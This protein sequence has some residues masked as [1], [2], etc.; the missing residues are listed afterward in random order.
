[1]K[2]LAVILNRESAKK[3]LDHCRQSPPRQEPAG[4][5]QQQLA[6]PGVEAA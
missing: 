2:I 3:I 1:M 6:L 4:R 5:R